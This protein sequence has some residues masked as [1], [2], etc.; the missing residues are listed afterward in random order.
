MTGSSVR[1]R[2][3]PP[4]LEAD[5]GAADPAGQLDRRT[6]VVD[7]EAA[8]RQHLMVDSVCRSVNPSVNSNSAPSTVMARKVV[9]APGCG[10]NGRSLP[11][12]DRNQRTGARSNCN[13][14]AAR[15]ASRKWTTFVP[16]RPE[17]PPQQ[18]EEVDADV[19]QQTA[20]SL[21]VA[22]PRNSYHRPRA[23]M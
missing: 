3:A 14:P 13:S 1:A 10:S 9:F 15:A 16:D 2:G 17:Q 12:V 7:A 19:Q 20:R 23:V 18:V 21:F 6:R 11:S 22:L 4:R 8:S 5:T